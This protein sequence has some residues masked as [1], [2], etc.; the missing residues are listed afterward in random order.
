MKESIVTKLIEDA[1]KRYPL[2]ISYKGFL[3]DDENDELRKTCEVRNPAV[4]MDGSAI[5]YIKY[6][7]DI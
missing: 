4:Y 1:K 3:S 5:Y 7:N 2:S 6:R